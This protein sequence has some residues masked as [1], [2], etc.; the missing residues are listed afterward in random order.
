MY[1]EK[2]M[3]PAECQNLHRDLIFIDDQVQEHEDG[4][5]SC[6]L[7]GKKLKV[8]SEYTAYMIEIETE[9]TPKKS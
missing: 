2:V 4:S 5:Y 8:E 9:C 6:R 7:C 1:S 3:N